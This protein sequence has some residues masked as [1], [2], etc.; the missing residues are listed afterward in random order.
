MTV[1]VAQD[2][3]SDDLRWLGPLVAEDVILDRREVRKSTGGRAPEGYVCTVPCQLKTPVLL[4]A[5]RA[6]LDRI[7]TVSFEDALR[8]EKR[9]HVICPFPENLDESGA[10]EGALDD[11]G[12]GHH[13]AGTTLGAWAFAPAIDRSSR[14]YLRDMPMA[15]NFACGLVAHE[16]GH[17]V[18]RGEYL[19]ERLESEVPTYWFV[20]AQ[21]NYYAIKW[22]FA[23]ELE[24]LRDMAN[25]QIITPWDL[26]REHKRIEMIPSEEFREPPYDQNGI[27]ES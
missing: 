17:A 12:G 3:A 9:V 6:V 11:R 8:L 4:E 25:V 23:E 16:F 15:A 5:V 21:A 24:S 27:Q 26:F 7:T 13:P 10:V 2:L 19:R 18:S 20:E 14:I 1:L 22:G